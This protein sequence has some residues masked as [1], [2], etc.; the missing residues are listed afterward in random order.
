MLLELNDPAAALAEFEAGLQTE[1]NR[2]RT[3]YGAATAARLSG[4]DDLSR[5]H[6]SALLKVCESADQP[7]RSE[8]L[9]AK[10]AVSA[11]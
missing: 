11:N 1:P 2:F 10:R 3:L 9:E 6:F 8:L 5:K 4:K 7:G